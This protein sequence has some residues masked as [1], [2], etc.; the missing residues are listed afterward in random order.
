MSSTEPSKTTE[1]RYPSTSGRTLTDEPEDESIR[2]YL[3]SHTLKTCYV[4]G[5][6]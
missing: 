3:V 1:R 6:G 4:P 5:E 2:A